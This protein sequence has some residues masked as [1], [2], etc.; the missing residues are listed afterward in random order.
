MNEE[1]FETFKAGI[2]PMAYAIQY[3]NDKQEDLKT[4]QIDYS[5]LK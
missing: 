3:L 5:L 4:K 1:L 2:V